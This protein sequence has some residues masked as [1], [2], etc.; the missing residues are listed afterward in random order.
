MQLNITERADIGTHF[1]IE[2]L[3]LGTVKILNEGEILYKVAHVYVRFVELEEKMC[4]IL[5][6]EE[7]LKNIVPVI[8]S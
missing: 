5:I 6:N 4:A 2:R 8:R 7:Q 1:N 3:Y